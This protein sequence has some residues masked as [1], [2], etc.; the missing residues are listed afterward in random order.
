[1]EVSKP[2]VQRIPGGEQRIIAVGP[3]QV[4]LSWW[5]VGA[6]NGAAF[7]RNLVPSSAHV[8]MYTRHR[9]AHWTERKYT[10]EHSITG[11]ANYKAADYA[12]RKY[13]RD[14]DLRP[15]HED[16]ARVV[17][18]ELNEGADI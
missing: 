14:N 4:V 17:A 16:L 1:M 7:A 2:R 12:A 5:Y 10:L 18:A 13:I 3:M 8:S 9:A 15:Q 11:I 6:N